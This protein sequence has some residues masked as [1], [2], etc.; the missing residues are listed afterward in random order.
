[1][2]ISRLIPQEDQLCK[3]WYLLF[4]INF[5]VMGV[6]RYVSYPMPVSLLVEVFY[7]ACI[8]ASASDEKNKG[9]IGRAACTMLFLY[10]P[11]VSYS[12]LEA[13]NLSAEIPYDIIFSRWFAEIRNM[14]F[15]VIYGMMVC[16]A[17]FVRKGQLH[18]MFKI[19]G[20][21]ILICTGKTLMQQYMGFDYAEAAFLAGGGARTHM[22]NG[23]I[24]YF[25]LFPDA[26]THGCCMAA[27]GA[28]F[29]AVM[30]S[31]HNKYE[32]IYYT[33]C[34][35]AAIYSMMASGTR[36]GIFVLGVGIMVYTALS[37]RITAII[38]SVILGGI[39][40][41]ILI[42]TDIGQGN[43]MIR[44]MRSAFN[45]DDASMAVRDMNQQ[46]MKRYVDELP[47]GLG[48]GIRNGDIPPSNKNYYLSIVPPDSTWVYVNIRYGN[49]G[50]YLFLF[51]FFGICFYSCFICFFRI[52]DP[53]LRGLL[54]GISSGATA[55]V[56]AGYANH[57][58]LQYPNCFIFFGQLMIVY[59]G[60]ELD[61]RIM[62]EQLRKDQEAL[63][64]AD[65]ESSYA[66]PL[67]LSE[68]E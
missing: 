65:P 17:I 4:F 22:V 37:K 26:A 68:Q 46:A 51:S 60:P 10:L 67:S 28:T 6:G 24:R 45:K 62:E 64:L 14:A 56:V 35:F 49:L 2:K 34:A 15:Q 53:E 1:M 7:F 36:T 63:A 44:R 23:I 50:K 20:L 57:I 41:G 59:L 61:R 48:A 13:G 29:L 25:S 39:F 5:F 12:V 38:S 9:N 30:L 18:T 55:M 54:A 42:F 31:V 58:Q 32:K 21:C 16:A 52:R 47:L 27:S 66:H 43:A 33:I 8:I 3:T 40:M 11:W 19:W